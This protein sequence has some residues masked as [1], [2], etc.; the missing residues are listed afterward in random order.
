MTNIEKKLKQYQDAIDNSNIVSKT[1]IDGKITFV[2]DEF[3]K[4]C[5]YTRDELIGKNH[6]I[7]RHPDVS[8]DTFAKLWETILSKKIHK[9][10]VKNLAKDGSSFFWSTTIV[11]ILDNDGNIEEFV[12]IRQ[13]VTSLVETNQQLNLAK[14]EL[15]ILNS[16]LADKVK[17]QTQCLLELNKNLEKR[18]YEEVNKNEE[19]TRV[20]FQQSRLASMGEMIGNIAH[21]W[22]QP[23]NEIGIDAFKMKQSIDNEEVLT[24]AYNHLKLV[25]KS[26][27]KT[28][29]DFRDFFNVNREKELFLVSQAIDDAKNLIK[30][31]IEREL[32]Y[33]KIDVIDDFEIFG[34]KSELTQV[35]LN[36]IS[37]AKDALKASLQNNKT[38]YVKIYEEEKFGYISIIDNGGGIEQ[39]I[40]DRIFEPYFTTKHPNHGT[41]LGLYMS[42]MIVEHMNGTIS[43][44][45]LGKNAV[46]EIKIPIK[47]AD[48]E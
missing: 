6:N 21:Q 2:N 27:S 39:N 17:A 9:G 36:L 5:G 48:N 42:K 23:L 10:V 45:N 34:F 8:R 16:S 37:N 11:P 46:F 18:V 14:D 28:I 47:G 38:I 24:N 3:C 20:L 13:D 29:D 12:A 44:R 4:I 32:I 33:L 41:G 43:A 19:K 30:G 31:Q 1:D 22:R 26:M 7:I 35:A 15:K 40:I 25:I